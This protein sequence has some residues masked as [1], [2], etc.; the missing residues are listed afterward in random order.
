MEACRKD[1]RNFKKDNG[2]KAIKILE[3]R[4]TAIALKNQNFEVIRK[5]IDNIPTIGKFIRE[6]REDIA[7]REFF[8]TFPTC[9]PHRSEH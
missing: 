7:F 4:R 1:F 9:L 2:N 8:N 5:Q 6:G 3:F